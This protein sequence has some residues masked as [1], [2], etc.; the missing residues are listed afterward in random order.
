MHDLCAMNGTSINK[1]LHGNF[2]SYKSHNCIK[3][4]FAIVPYYHHIKANKVDL[5]IVTGD[6]S[7]F[8]I[9]GCL[10]L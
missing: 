5:I 6:S 8:E 2:H 3:K 9:R 4:V 1:I 10:G 7:D